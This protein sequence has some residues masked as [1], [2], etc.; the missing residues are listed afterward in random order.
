MKARLLKML[1]VTP[2]ESGPVFLLLAIS[3]L[4]GMFLATVTVASQTL[5][6]NFFDE[7]EQLPRALFISGVFGLISTAVYNFLQGRIPFPVLAIGSL[8][9]VAIL[10]AGIEFGDMFIPQVEDLYY[11]GFALIL[12]FVFLTRLVFWGA[13]NR[14]FNLKQSKRIIGSVDVGTMIAAI[15][16]FF[17]I[18]ILLNFG[19]PVESLFTVSLFSIIGFLL[20]FIVLSA[21]YLR[22]EAIVAAE[23]EHKKISIG[24]F[25]GNRYIV[26]MSLFIILSMIALRFI[27]FSFFNVSTIRFNEVDLPYFLSLFEGLIVVFSFLFT[28]FAADYILSNYGLR[29]SLLLNPLIVILFTVAAILTGTFFGFDA[30]SGEAIIFFFITVSMSK[31]FINSFREALDEPAFKFYYVPIDRSIKI[32]AQTKIE[33]FVTALASVLAGG[34]IV[35]INQFKIFDLLSITLFTVPFL[36]GWYFVVNRMYKGYRTTLQDSLV[37]SKAAEQEIQK[38]FTLDSVLEKEVLSRTEDKVIYG[39]RLMEKLEPALFETSVLSLANS[40]IPRVK[41]FALQKIQ[42]LGVEHPDEIKDLAREAAGALEESDLLGISPE[43]L[44]KLSKS[45]KQTDRILATKLLRK[46]VSQ[47]TIFILLELLRDADP[48]VRV[49]ALATARRVKRPETFPVLVEM[50]SSPVYSYHAAA[51]LKE[52]G[53]IAL[54]ALE[55]AFHKSGQTDQIMLKIIQIMGFIGGKEGIELLWKKMDYPDKRIVKQILYSLRFINYQ[56]KGREITAVKDLLDVE[57]GKT[58]WNLSALEE[59]PDDQEEFKFL[60]DALAEEVRDNYDHITLLLSLLYD[61]QSVQLVRE[62]IETGTPDSTAYALELLDLF[63]DQDMKPKIIP[64]MDDDDASSKLEKLRTYFPRENYNVIQVLNY[65]FNRDFNYTNRWTKASA[66]HAAA[67]VKDFRVSRGLI[68]QMF[69]KDRLLQEMAAFVIYNKDKQI[70]EVVSQ[71]LP[72]KDKRFLDTSI[73]NNQ[74]LDG[75]EDGFYLYMEMVMFIKQI[76]VFKNIAGNLLCDL[77]DKIIPLDLPS[78]KKIQFEDDALSPIIIVAHGEVRIT[79]IDG[80]IITMKSGD[81]HGDLFQEGAAVKLKELEATER[82]IVF[83]INMIDFYFVLANHHE[84]VQG[85]I[86]NITGKYKKVTA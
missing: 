31:L 60:R 72:L 40:T 1:D 22:S 26:M 56:A 43:K 25:I 47:K 5:F 75:L 21:K 32:D 58:L 19:L 35:I 14:M 49:E 44:M 62:N 46:L 38:D 54:P 42:E 45:I 12:P 55:T 36:I 17:T 81:I 66:V 27:E 15:L 71:R 51:A 76:P 68:G 52:A 28:T 48:K 82:A 33:G 85:L 9:V 4:M 41:D 3:F 77:A 80:E 74:L 37:K 64:L 65:I 20:L 59:L 69:N 39:L 30:A 84:L 29:V 86:R 13:F 53:K 79:T 70:Y 23:Q 11:Y 24:K 16:A 34:S 50:I 2:E 61:P 73:Q 7:F 6:L 10:T 57:M 83:R 67:F 63:V 18:P 78:R 8:V